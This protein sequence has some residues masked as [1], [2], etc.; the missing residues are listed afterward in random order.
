MSSR[1]RDR[2][3]PRRT[4]TGRLSHGRDHVG[5]GITGSAGITDTAEIT[6]G[7]TDTACGATDGRDG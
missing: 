7:I 3:S 4:T 6:D 5:I 1:D 2:L